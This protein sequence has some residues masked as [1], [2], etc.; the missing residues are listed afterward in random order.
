MQIVFIDEESI[1]QT[2]KRQ[3]NVRIFFYGTL[4]LLIALVTCTFVFQ[5]RETMRIWIWVSSLFTFLFLAVLL[6]LGFAFLSPY[7][8]Y[9]SFMK[10][11]LAPNA[12]REEIDGVVL[13]TEKDTIHGKIPYHKIIVEVGEKKVTLFYDG[14]NPFRFN[15]GCTYHFVIYQNVILSGAEHEVTPE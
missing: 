1:E 11:A 3:K 14:T 7:R 15:S 13:S 8:R 6:Y 9:L 4:L 5:T 2:K 12:L 10:K